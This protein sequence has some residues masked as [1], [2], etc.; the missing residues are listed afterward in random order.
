M[1]MIIN[2]TYFLEINK[3]YSKIKLDIKDLYEN[4]SEYEKISKKYSK[5]DFYFASIM[6]AKSI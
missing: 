4:D 5:M 1:A 2:E 6:R 3:Q